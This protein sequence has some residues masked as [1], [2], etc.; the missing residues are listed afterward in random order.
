MNI[1]RFPCYPT[2]SGSDG[3]HNDNLYIDDEAGWCLF[4]VEV[5]N[6]YGLSFEVSFERTQEGHSLFMQES[7]HVCINTSLQ[8]R[9]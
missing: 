1:I 8:A 2:E 6:T 5:R 7:A 3:A 4:S 9:P